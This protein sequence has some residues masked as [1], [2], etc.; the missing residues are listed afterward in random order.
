[1]EE[2]TLQEKMEYYVEG[3]N[4]GIHLVHETLW[5]LKKYLETGEIIDYL[6]DE[7]DF[8]RRT[9]FEL[10]K[11]AIDYAYNSAD[12]AQDDSMDCIEWLRKKELVR[13]DFFDCLDDQAR[14]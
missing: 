8:P 4:S 12:R 1:M 5:A 3:V 11:D 6:D 13:Q 9:P 7:V 10:I 14:V 2:K